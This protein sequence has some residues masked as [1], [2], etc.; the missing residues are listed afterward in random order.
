LKIWRIIFLVAVIFIMTLLWFGT[1]LDLEIG[2]GGTQ[3]N[4]KINQKNDIENS[5]FYHQYFSGDS[6]IVLNYWATWCKPCIEEMP[7]LNEVKHHYQGKNI[8]FISFSVD[9][10]SLKLAKFIASKRFN[11]KDITFQ[12][13]QYRNAI[14]NI[15]R[16]KKSEQ[17]VGAYAVPMTF[18]I[19]KGK[20]LE[21]EV[22]ALDR[23]ELIEMI[24]KYN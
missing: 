13:R 1:K 22:G 2:G 20:V 9:D 6:L 11:F 21:K 4:L 8:V 7:M 18:I 14:I 23:N 17:W 19:K 5:N 16:G 12:N 24:N 15:L 10:D 3:S